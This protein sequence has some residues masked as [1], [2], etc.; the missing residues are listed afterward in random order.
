M[1]MRGKIAA[2]TGAA[3]GIGRSVALQLARNGASLI[4]HTRS[5]DSG[6]RE[7]ARLAEEINPA[8][9]VE[10]ILQDFAETSHQDRFCE[11]AWNWKQRVDCLINNAGVDVL[12]GAAAKLEFEEK[13]ELLYRVDIV[14]TMRISRELGRKMRSIPGGAIINVGWDQADHGMEGDSGEMFAAIKGAV[15]AFSKSLAKS[16]APEVR[17]NCVAPGWIQTAWGDNTSEYWNQRATS[18][19]LLRTWGVPEDVAATIGFLASPEARFINGQVIS[20]NGGFDHGA[21]ARR[22]TNGS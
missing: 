2:V 10:L 22:P 16:L 17:V 5:N 21:A 6:L 14:A 3:S 12:T 4:L 15:M 11:Q 1:N 8:I 20:V 18:E 7:T 13:L 19:S 9:E